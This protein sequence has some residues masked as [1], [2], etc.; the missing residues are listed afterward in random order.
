MVW[1]EL[2]WFATAAANLSAKY[3]EE[4]EE[5]AASLPPTALAQEEWRQLQQELDRLAGA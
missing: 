5:V 2:L 1:T 4:L 3:R